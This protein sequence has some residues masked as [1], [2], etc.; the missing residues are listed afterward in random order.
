MHAHGQKDDSATS[1]SKPLVALLGLCI[2]GFI[3]LLF[4][5]IACAAC[6]GMGERCYGV[7]CGVSLLK[8]LLAVPCLGAQRRAHK[9]GIGAALYITG[10]HSMPQ[11]IREKRVTCGS[12]HHLLHGMR[13]N[14]SCIMPHDTVT[15]RQLRPCDF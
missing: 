14:A 10:G 13:M 1:S 4:E 8:Q 6:Q 9:H 15:V 3:K 7:G 5:T 12:W 2:V 11:V